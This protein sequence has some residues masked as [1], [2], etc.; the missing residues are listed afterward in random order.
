MRKAFNYGIFQ[1]YEKKCREL[2]CHK[3][4]TEVIRV[5]RRRV[6]FTRLESDV[7]SVSEVINPGGVLISSH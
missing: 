4:T 5:G 3:L 7:L 2:G 6:R 1:I